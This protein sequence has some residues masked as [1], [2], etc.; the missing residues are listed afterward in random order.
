MLLCAQDFGLPVS[1]QDTIVVQLNQDEADTIPAYREQEQ[2][3]GEVVIMKKYETEGRVIRMG[4]SH[5]MN[6]LFWC[7]L[8]R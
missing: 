2:L 5:S 1:F 3:P 6:T 8:G 4:F 7:E